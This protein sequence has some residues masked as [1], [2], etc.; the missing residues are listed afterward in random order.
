MHSLQLFIIYVSVYIYIYYSLEV[1]LD[2]PSNLNLLLNSYIHPKYF[3]YLLYSHII[4]IYNPMS[5]FYHLKNIHNIFFYIC[6]YYIC[7]S[8]LLYLIFTNSF[9]YNQD[10]TNL[11]SMNLLENQMNSYYLRLYILL[12]NQFLYFMNFDSLSFVVL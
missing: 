11:Q 12:F 5:I 8:L 2:F 10:Q 9:R 1:I 6:F 4:N 3:Y 7:R